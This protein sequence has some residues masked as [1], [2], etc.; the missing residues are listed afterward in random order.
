MQGKSENRSQANSPQA[1]ERARVGGGKDSQQHDWVSRNRMVSGIFF[2]CGHDIRVIQS[3]RACLGVI[4]VKYVAAK[5][6][7]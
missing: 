2:I 5:N 7:A 6:N 4:F 1:V 3:T